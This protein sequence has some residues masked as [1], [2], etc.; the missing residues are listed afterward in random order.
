[1]ARSAFL[2]LPPGPA[3][4]GPRARLRRDFLPSRG[5]EL[6]LPAGSVRGD[7]SWAPSPPRAP[8]ALR[9]GPG[10]APP[11]WSRPGNPPLS[12]TKQGPHRLKS[13]FASCFC[14]GP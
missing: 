13:G 9:L 4:R 1:M 5:C 8:A 6:M 10:A 3:A 14:R 12:G 11:L 2:T 7:C